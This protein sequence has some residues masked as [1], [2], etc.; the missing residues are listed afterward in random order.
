[1]AGLD[2]EKFQPLTTGEAMEA[3]KTADWKTAYWDSLSTI[4]P[5]D[6]A[7]IRVIDGTMVGMGLISEQELA[8]IHEIG[9]R[10]DRYRN[11]EA[12]LSTAGRAEMA[13]SKSG[14]E[15]RKAQ[16]KQEAAAR[17]DARAQ[18]I[19][20][21]KQNDIVFLGRGVSKGL[22]DRRA[23]IEK[24]TANGLPVLSTPAELATALD[25]TVSRLRWLSYHSEAPT[26]V[27]YVSFE[28]PKKSGGVRRL[29]APHAR[30]ATC[31]NWILENILNRL[32]VHDAAHGFVTGRSTV[33][34]ATPHLQAAVVVNADL[35]DFFPTIHFYRIEGLFRS[36]G[37]SPAVAT[38]LGLLTTECPRDEVLFQGDR[39]YP[40]VGKRALPQGAC[41][42]PAL[43]NLVSRNLDHRLQGIAT[44]LGWTF[45]RYA[46]DLTFSIKQD[47]REQVGYLLAR[48]RHI[49]QDEGF[50]VNEKKTRVL[51]RNTRQSVTGIVV[52]DRL[53][54]PRS[55]VRRVRAILHQA[56]KTGLD[57]QNRENHPHFREWVTGMV[58]YINM[59]NPEQGNKLRESLSRL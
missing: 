28:V 13:R 40:A 30:L 43:S 46:D 3:T 10:M 29:S 31:Q 15:R 57:A 58:A 42:S 48:I 14:Q 12:H 9:E 22:A 11:R 38:I 54:I 7:R 39:Y 47:S 21:R 32:P 1:M 36:F 6:L 19:V 17:K 35:S 33:S 55:Q 4:P 8:E 5:A 20:E 49:C 41:T 24:L 34:N 53:S 59:V 2:T 52:N 18:Q 50:E 51:G 26:R 25:L 56:Q 27:H 23:N 16:K 45:T 37:Y 44:K